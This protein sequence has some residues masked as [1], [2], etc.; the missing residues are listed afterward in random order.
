[1]LCCVE[2]GGLARPGR[3]AERGSSGST[4]AVVTGLLRVGQLA[5]NDLEPTGKESQRPPPAPKS[6][7]ARTRCTARDARWGRNRNDERT[8]AQRARGIGQLSGSQIKLPPHYIATTM[9]PEAPGKADASANIPAVWQRGSG[10]SSGQA[11]AAISLY[12]HR[13]GPLSDQ[14]ISDYPGELLVNLSPAPF[15]LTN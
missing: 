7:A 13:P 5:S 15:P 6:P 8:E 14:A 1:M 11:A 10:L 9:N 3:G 4:A 2:R 12:T